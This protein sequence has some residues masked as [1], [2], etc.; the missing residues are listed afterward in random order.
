MRTHLTKLQQ[1][2]RVHVSLSGQT[3]SHQVDN[4]QV[5]GI[6]QLSLKAIITLLGVS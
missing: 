6:L 1:E 5:P 3:N 4:V 2:E